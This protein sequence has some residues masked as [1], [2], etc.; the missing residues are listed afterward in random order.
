MVRGGRQAKAFVAQAAPHC[1]PLL[2][3]ESPPPLLSRLWSNSR[4][5]LCRPCCRIWADTATSPPSCR[6]LRTHPS[7]TGT[8]N[9]TCLTQTL[10]FGP[11]LGIGKIDGQL[12]NGTAFT[13]DWYYSSAFSAIVACRT[14]GSAEEFG[15]SLDTTVRGAGALNVQ[16][17]LRAGGRGGELCWGG[18]WDQH[19]VLLTSR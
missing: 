7:V 18:W 15:Y 1:L 12:A 5:L 8:R 16:A 13:C 9:Y 19:A 2:L 10:S 3:A 17:V 11:S 4:F 6:H 14:E